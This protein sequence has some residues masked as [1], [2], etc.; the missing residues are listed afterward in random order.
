MDVLIDEEY[1]EL[2]VKSSLDKHNG[3]LVMN[4]YLD[5]LYP[6]AKTS[7]H[8]VIMTRVLGR[9]LLSTE[10]VHHINGNK[11]DN[12]ASNLR[13]HTRGEHAAT[14]ATGSKRSDETRKKMSEKAKERNSREEY[15]AILSARVVQQHKNGNFGLATVKDKEK[16]KEK[17]AEGVRA[18][19]NSPESNG[20]RKASSERMKKTQEKLWSDPKYK[21]R[22]APILANN[23]RKR[24]GTL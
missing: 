18:F 24:H 21:E 15:K 12:R 17:S 1:K 13:L 16:M 2:L 6:T 9:R 11:L 22:M 20:V 19:Y 5:P 3:Y 14:H 7:L 8:R 23:A 10:L 4:T